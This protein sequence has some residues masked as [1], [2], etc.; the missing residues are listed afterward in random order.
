MGERITIQQLICNDYKSDFMD[1]MIEET[2]KAQIIKSIQDM[3][4]KEIA[5]ITVDPYQTKYTITLK[6]LTGKEEYKY[7]N[8]ISS[9]I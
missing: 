7:G 6:F 5:D 9:N 3:E 8:S 4:F 1:K 2:M